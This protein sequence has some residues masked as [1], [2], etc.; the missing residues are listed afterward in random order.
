MVRVTNLKN[1]TREHK[2]KR[3]RVIDPQVAYSNVSSP[4][5]SNSISPSEMNWWN[6]L[7]LTI[8]L[9]FR[10]LPYFWFLFL[11]CL[12][13]FVNPTEFPLRYYNLI[14]FSILMVSSVGQNLTHLYISYRLGQKFNIRKVQKWKNLA[15]ESVLAKDLRVGDLVLVAKAEE[16][17]ADILLM[18][19]EGGKR[20][21]F[22]KSKVLGTKDYVEKY[23]VDSFKIL[24]ELDHNEIFYSLTKIDTINVTTPN[25]SFKQF[26][27]KIRYKGDPKTYISG[28]SNFVIG[29]SILVSGDWVLGLVFIQE[30]KLNFG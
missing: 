1:E 28:L 12:E 18:D 4:Y 29:G 2:G 10:K 24:K 26:K 23:P 8:Y 21:I 30:W 16:I 7:P 9:E 5:I 13:M 15:F 11:I 22:D 20:A 27:A 14:S 17:P 19:C 3:Y 25:P 6:I